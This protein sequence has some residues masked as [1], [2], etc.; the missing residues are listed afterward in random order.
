MEWTTACPDWERRILA[1][2]SLVPV[3]PLFPTERTEAMEVFKQLRV[4]DMAGKPTMG[5]V[6]RDW[7]IDFVGSVFGSYDPE[8]GRRLITEFF[9][10]ISKKNTKSTTAAGIMLTALIRNWRHSAEFLILAPTIEIANNSFFPARDMVNSDDE[11]SELLQVQDHTR[12]ITHRLTGATLKVVAADS[13]TVGGKKATGVLIDELW[14]FG[15]RPNAENMLREACGGLASR[16]EGFTIFLSTQSDEPPAGVFRQKLNY[17]RGVRDGRI[18]DKRFL[19]VI[20]EFP[21]E[22]IK[23][24][25]HR[26]PANFFVTNPNMG[27]SVDTEFLLR[28][29]QKANE[30]G[31]ESMRGF[32]AKHLNVEI[33]LALRSDRW[34]GAEFWEAQARPAG[35]SF[36]YLLDRSEV[37]DVGI[38]GGGLDDLLGFAAIGRDRDTREWL[39]WTHAWAHPSVLIRRKS[40]AARFHD[41]AR[42]GHLTLVKTIGDDVAEVAQLVARIE[43]AGL[44]DKVGVDPAGVGAILDALVEAEVPEEKVIGI[45]Q[46]WKLG[47]AIKTTERRLAEGGLVHGGQ[48]LMNWCCGNARVEP[49]GNSILITKQ[50]SGFAKIDPLMATFNAVSLIS[51]NP[52]AQGGL[53]NYLSGGFFGLIGSN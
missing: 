11:L 45:S 48:P 37:I 39:L 47:G 29:F 50:A 17:A 25:K 20:Y 2:E 49:R 3:V 18:N 23:A 36:E 41:F 33:G 6:S 22:M 16:P 1:S 32:L 30:D 4:A 31:E 53:D 13:D 44:L 27:A 26:D 43:M 14:L 51:L 34:A 52:Q 35:V 40:E 46:G 5:E 24:N 8:Q 10:L 42:D 7:I 28:E 19:P 12:T 21:E 9:L 15:K 38:D